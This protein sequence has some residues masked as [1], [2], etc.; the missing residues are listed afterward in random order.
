MPTPF[1]PLGT[2]LVLTVPASSPVES[3]TFTE[4]TTLNRS[5]LKQEFFDSTTLASAAKGYVSGLPDYGDAKVSGFLTS[6]QTIADVMDLFASGQ[7]L[8]YVITVKKRGGTT[9]LTE[10]GKC[11]VDSP[12]YQ[13]Q[14]NGLAT[15]AFSIKITA[16]NSG[17]PPA[18][19]TS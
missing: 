19:A 16:D 15:F 10:T 6:G 14:V 13:G 8:D 18:F 7:Q 5:G 11:Y 1:L 9:V 3:Y 17:N 4:L 12:E 2:Q